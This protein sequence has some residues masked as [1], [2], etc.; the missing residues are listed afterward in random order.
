MDIVLM[1]IGK[2]RCQ[3][4]TAGITE[5]AARLKRYI[6]F[7]IIEI[8]D[9]KTTRSLSEQLQKEKEGELILARLSTADFVIL[10]DEHGKEY[11]SVE[12]ASYLEKLM[13][14]GR[15]R[16]VFVVGGPYGFSESVYSRGDAKIS[17]SRMTFNHEM[18][19]MFFVEQLYRSMT[20]IRGEPYHH[21]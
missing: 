12:F 16:I 5:F 9:L 2:T 21:E 10:L 20:I 18:V 1:T 19:R 8:P 13:A 3:F 17:L 11:S 6:P 7:S 15:K 14:M 4:V